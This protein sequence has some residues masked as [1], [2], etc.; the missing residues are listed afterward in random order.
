VRKRYVALLAALSLTGAASLVS[1]QAAAHRSGCHSHH[2]C[3]SDHATY[4]WRGLL[5][6]KPGADEYTRSFWRVVYYQGRKYYCK[7]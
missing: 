6:V 2:T 4:R 7:R 5:C 3:P 1:T